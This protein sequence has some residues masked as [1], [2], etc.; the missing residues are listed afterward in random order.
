MVPPTVLLIFVTATQIGSRV[1]GAL[2]IFGLVRNTSCR[3]GYGV[4]GYIV[5]TLPSRIPEL[6]IE[7]ECQ[8]GY[9]PDKQNLI[10]F[11]M[12]RFSFQIRFARDA[13]VV[14]M[15]VILVNA[16]R[17]VVA[18]QEHTLLFCADGPLVLHKLVVDPAH[19]DNQVFWNVD[20]T[21]LK[22]PSAKAFLVTT[23]VSTTRTPSITLPSAEM[24]GGRMW[25]PSAAFASLYFQDVGRFIKPRSPYS[26]LLSCWLV[27]VADVNRQLAIKSYRF[28]SVKPR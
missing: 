24:D 20:C 14:S 3:V 27:T 17:S 22:S 10:R 13:T 6:Y 9:H 26:A 28:G 25:W 18:N 5:N 12:L 16:S 1:A 8:D 7:R 21:E 15:S 4:R 19:F 11:F 2:L 23:D